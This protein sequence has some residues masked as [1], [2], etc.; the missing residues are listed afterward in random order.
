MKILINLF[1]LTSLVTNAYTLSFITDLKAK[2]YNDVWGQWFDKDVTVYAGSD[3]DSSTI[4]FV[5]EMNLGEY[6]HDY[7]FSGTNVNQSSDFMEFYNHLKKAQEWSKIAKDNNAE[8][9]R[10][11]GGCSTWST[12]CKVSFE[13]TNGGR[14]TSAMLYIKEDDEWSF[15][16]GNFKINSNVLDQLLLKISPARL[17]KTLA[18]SKNK[19]NQADDLFN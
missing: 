3:G 17:N 4:R 10:D 2:E 13:S 12:I 6:N 5:F 11:I 1:L 9:N 15:N 19:N 18:E 7:R 8:T 14:S 16:E